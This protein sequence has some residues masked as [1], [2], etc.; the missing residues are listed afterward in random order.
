[1]QEQL[2]NAAKT[3]LTSAVA[4]TDTTINVA[5]ASPFPT[6]GQ[7]RLLIDSEYLLCTS[8]S[9]D[10]LTVTRGVEGSAA[11]SHLSGATVT[12]V[13][14]AG[15]VSNA[16]GRGGAYRVAAPQNIAVAN[17]ANNNVAV[18]SGKVRLT[19]PTGAFSITGIAAPVDARGDVIDGAELLLLNT[20]AQALTLSNL[21][22]GSTATNQITTLTGAD[23]VLPSRTSFARLTYDA[24]SS[25]W[26]LTDHS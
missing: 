21:N 3:T 15:A 20:T 22:S 1:M 24:T 18:T 14:T 9:G 7:F 2:A 6:S 11:A 12:C 23:V 4:S 13:I 16:I 10:V 8:V 19:G 25:T 26:I 17:G 5:S